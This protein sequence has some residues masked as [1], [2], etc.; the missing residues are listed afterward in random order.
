MLGP[1]LTEETCPFILYKE[2]SKE[3]NPAKELEPHTS[4]YVDE[5]DNMVSIQM[6]PP[7]RRAQQWPYTTQSE[8]ENPNKEPKPHAYMYVDKRDNVVSIVMMPPRRRAQEC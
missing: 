3:E 1:I 5:I 7:R 4:M 8:E 2:Q 6:M